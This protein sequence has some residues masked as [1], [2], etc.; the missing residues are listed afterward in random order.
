[1]EKE[2]FE[3]MRWA[4]NDTYSKEEWKEYYDILGI[5]INIIEDTQ[6]QVKTAKEFL[7]ALPKLKNNEVIIWDETTT[8][9]IE[10]SIVK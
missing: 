7:E 1:M 10:K 2:K 9:L 8:R 4:D 6:I 3:E 5:K